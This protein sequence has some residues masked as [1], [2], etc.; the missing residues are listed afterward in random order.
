MLGNR[1]FRYW[2]KINLNEKKDIKAFL[3]AHKTSNKLK[4]ATQTGINIPE[5]YFLLHIIYDEAM[6][7]STQK[8]NLAA[9]EAKLE[10][11]IIKEMIISCLSPK[12]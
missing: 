6:H 11:I 12:L 5:P 3:T 9:I 1:F 4:L 8:N 2:K 10:N 7:S